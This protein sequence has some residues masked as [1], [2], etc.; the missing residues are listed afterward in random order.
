[1]GRTRRSLL[2]VLVLVAGVATDCADLVAALAGS[3]GGYLPRRTTA[4]CA[5]AAV[6][7]EVGV[8]DAVAGATEAAGVLRVS[9]VEL[10]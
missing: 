2:A 4:L 8:S 3:A 10:R 1:M 7:A 5:A 9:A 6:R